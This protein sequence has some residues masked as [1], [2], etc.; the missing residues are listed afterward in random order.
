[1][2]IEDIKFQSNKQEIEDP[3]HH[4]TKPEMQNKLDDLPICDCTNH[5]HQLLVGELVT[6]TLHKVILVTDAPHLFGT[7]Y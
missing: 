4:T 7:K 5:H 1:M 2:E 6:T 3:L